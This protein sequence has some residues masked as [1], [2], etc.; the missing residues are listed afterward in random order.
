MF[1]FTFR[2]RPGNPD[3]YGHAIGLERP[4]Y[5]S[6]KGNSHTHLSVMTLGEVEM[7]N[8]S[9]VSRI[10]QS[11]VHDCDVLAEVLS[12]LPSN[13]IGRLSLGLP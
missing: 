10:L 2:Q 3:Q 7:N 13:L 12:R 1:V 9:S 6:V 8:T 5:T 4:P 11:S